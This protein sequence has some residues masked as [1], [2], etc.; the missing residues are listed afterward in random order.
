VRLDLNMNEPRRVMIAAIGWTGHLF[1][2]LALAREL[3][4]RGNDVLVESFE[5]W[6]PVVEGLGLRFS[7]APES[8]AFPGV[9]SHRGDPTLAQTAREVASRLTDRPPDVVVSDLFTLAPALAAETIGIRRATLIPHPYPVRAP[10]LPF[11]PLG[12]LPPRTP[13][14]ALAW[15]ALWPSVGTRLPNTRLRRVRGAIDRTRADLGLA[16]LAD[17]D[18]Q[19][20]DQLALV[21][22]FPQ[23]E[24]PRP[25]PRHVHVTGPMP[26]EVPYPDAELPPGKGPLVLVASSTE[27]DRDLRLVRVVLDALAEEP[28]RVLAS[29]NRRGEPWPS[30]TPANSRVVD[31]ISYSQA[32]PRASLVVGHGGHGTTTRAIAEGV[33]VL[34]SPPAGDMA[35]VGARVAWSGAGLVL[36][37]RLLRA[38]AVRWVVRKLLADRRFTARAGELAAWGRR[39]DG[40]GIG[41]GL[42]ERLAGGEHPVVKG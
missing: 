18:G 30:G 9:A 27:R 14:G 16:P 17:Y 25:W 28:V 38:G 40:A 42:V 20:S 36:P 15:R 7:A 2:A 26:F 24:Y 23:L 35:E 39:N 8:I 4:A 5:R 22:T 19:I 6:R 31:W 21:A 29:T 33:P 12:L 11:Y 34:I 37:T 3:H 41:A 1:P 10:G 32:M 13:V